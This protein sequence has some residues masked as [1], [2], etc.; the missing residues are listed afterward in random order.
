[1]TY[2]ISKY[3]DD[4]TA[5]TDVGKDQYNLAIEEYSDVENLYIKA[6]TDLLALDKSEQLIISIFQ[7]IIKWNSVSSKRYSIDKSVFEMYTKDYQK[8]IYRELYDGKRIFNYC[9]LADL[10]KIL[11]HT[12]EFNK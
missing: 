6:V 12:L 10:L 1:M 7:K 4:W 9:E 8:W 3:V 2:R 11:L 5:L